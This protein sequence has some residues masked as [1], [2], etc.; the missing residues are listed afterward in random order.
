[1][2][3]V[4]VGLPISGLVIDYKMIDEWTEIDSIVL[5]WERM[6]IQRD[7][8]LR[9][10]WHSQMRYEWENILEGKIHKQNILVTNKY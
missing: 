5:L 1:M 10:R 3:I 8:E 9:V 7:Q 6:V 2:A 4:I